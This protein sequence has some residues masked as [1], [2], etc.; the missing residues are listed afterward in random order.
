M[1][2]FSCVKNFPQQY[3]RMRVKR[4]SQHFKNYIKNK[5]FSGFKCKLAIQWNKKK[6]SKCLYCLLNAVLKH[7]WASV[8]LAYPRK[9]IQM[10]SVN[11]YLNIFNIRIKSHKTMITRC[12]ILCIQTVNLFF[13]TLNWQN[14]VWR[15]LQEML[16][17]HVRMHAWP[18]HKDNSRSCH[19]DHSPFS[20]CRSFS[21]RLCSQPP[22]MIHSHGEMILD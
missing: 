3:I 10:S 12:N 15:C 9:K 5:F 11:L 20:G 22:A 4:R 16:K 2:D 14:L 1:N 13:M 7:F 21:K 6:K 19:L 8:N 18:A 17:K